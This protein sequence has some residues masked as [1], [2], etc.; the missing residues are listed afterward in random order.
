[1]IGEAAAQRFAPH[2]RV[3]GI[4][5]PQRAKRTVTRLGTG[6]VQQFVERFVGRH[7]VHGRQGRQGVPAEGRDIGGR[8]A[9]DRRRLFAIQIRQALRPSR[10]ALRDSA[11]RAP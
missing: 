9:Q 5:R 3:R 6:H 4:A 7:V 10:T 11:S 8:P 2:E 1:M